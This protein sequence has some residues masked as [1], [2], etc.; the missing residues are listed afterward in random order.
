MLQKRRL[1]KNLRL[2]EKL[3]LSKDLLNNNTNNE[4]N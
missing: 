4:T 2:K 3:I 1:E